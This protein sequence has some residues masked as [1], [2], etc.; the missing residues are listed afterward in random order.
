MK[1]APAI[2]ASLVF[3]GL[4]HALMGKWKPAYLLLAIEIIGISA[5]L[6]FRSLIRPHETE[7][8]FLTVV[9]IH[10]LS[11]ATTY[12]AKPFK[13]SAIF[14]LS[15]I[16]IFTFL[17]TGSL[18]GVYLGK[19]KLFGLEFYYIPSSSMTPTLKPGDVILVDLRAYK[20]KKPKNGD[21]ITFRKP[22]EPRKILVKRVQ[23]NLAE[24][25]YYVIGDNPS[26]SRD[27]RHYGPIKFSSITGRVI[28]PLLN[29][30]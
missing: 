20:D 9:T 14:K 4:G 28:K 5:V 25:E 16:A 26:A 24:E 22:E 10:L 13:K 19:S 3:P 8:F 12:T 18:L 27:S 2:L 1:K 17:A 6:Y 23:A 15:S 21:I 11:A 29:I 30:K 7:A